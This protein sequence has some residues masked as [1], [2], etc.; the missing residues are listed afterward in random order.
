MWGSNFT[1]LCDVNLGEQTIKA[2]YKP[3]QGERPL[4]DFPSETLAGREVSAYLVS[5]AGGWH[6]VPPTVFRADSQAGGGSL[7]FFV[8]HDPE[9]HYFNFTP[10]EKERL[11]PVV[12]FDEII[13][14]TDRKGGHIIMDDNDHIWLI[15]HGVCFHAESK[16]RTVVWDFAD[17]LIPEECLEQV[18]VFKDKL[19][20]EQEVYQE[21]AKHLSEIEIQAMIVRTDGLLKT[22]TFPSPSEG[23]RYYPW[24]PV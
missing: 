16:L 24:P 6:M 23:R 10:E 19:T 2:V 17:Q 21:L 18:S 1:F 8:E 14:N 20:P 11:K 3:T 4:W 13:N 5:E 22:K 7:Q 15:D 12:L 9:Y